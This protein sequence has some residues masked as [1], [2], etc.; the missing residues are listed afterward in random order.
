MSQGGHS[1]PLLLLALFYQSTPS[2]LKVRG[3]GGGVGGP[4]DYCVSPSPFSLDFGTLDFGTSDSGL[5]KML[6]LFFCT[7]LPEHSFMLKSYWVVGWVG[8][9]GGPCDSSVSPSPF[10][11]DFW[12][13][14]LGLTIFFFSN[15]SKFTFS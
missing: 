15:S 14:E 11:L 8:G 3:G 2:C 5:T 13:S 6:D 9:G 12:T 7:F 4:C 10:G 1:E